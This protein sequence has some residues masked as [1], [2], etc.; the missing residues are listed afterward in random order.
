M[1]ITK[2]TEKKPRFLRRG[3]EEEDTL[4]H[5]AIPIKREWDKEKR[6]SPPTDHGKIC[7]Q[8]CQVWTEHSYVSRRFVKRLSG[9]VL[10]VEL[11]FRCSACNKDR[12]WGTE[13]IL[14]AAKAKS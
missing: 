5:Q 6:I 7:C 10:Y 1:Q 11:M 8:D 12:V 2:A 13:D 4:Y 14:K 3:I 9:E